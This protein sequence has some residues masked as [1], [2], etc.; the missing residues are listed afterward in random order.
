[1][2]G[3]ASSAAIVGSRPAGVEVVE[4][5]P[6]AHAALGR[7]PERLEQQVA[8]L[9]AVPDV[10]LRIER[11]FRGGGEQHARGE[12]VAWHSGQRMDPGLARIRGD[13]RRDR[14][15]EPRPRR[16]G[17]SA[18]RGPAF[19]RGQ[20]RAARHQRRER[21]DGESQNAAHPNGFTT[22]R[23]QSPRHP[24]QRQ[25]ACD[26]RPIAGDGH[27]RCRC[28]ELPPSGLRHPRPVCSARTPHGSGWT[29][30]NR[31]TSAS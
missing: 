9:V 31:W 1:M 14:A 7:L 17:E 29:F 22:R 24:L 2:F 11:L 13:I 10:V 8:D 30:S 12:G 5:Q 3:C 6:H 21:G 4:Q 23:L 28:A 15:A 19:Q 25:R 20:A 27:G 18:R 26:Q 16:V